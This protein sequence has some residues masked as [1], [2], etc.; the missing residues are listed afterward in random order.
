MEFIKNIMVYLELN[1]ELNLNP[2]LKLNLMMNMMDTNLLQSSNYAPPCPPGI[3][4]DKLQ[5]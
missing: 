4:Q 3:N 1:L 5:I 2:E